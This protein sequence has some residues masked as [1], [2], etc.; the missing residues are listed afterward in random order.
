[1]QIIAEVVK[2]KPELEILIAD[3]LDPPFYVQNRQHAVM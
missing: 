3:A 1:M 2:E